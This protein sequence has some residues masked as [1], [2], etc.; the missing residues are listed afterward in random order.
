MVILILGTRA[1]RTVVFVAIAE[2]DDFV[3]QRRAGRPLEPAVE[4]RRHVLL[5]GVIAD[6][7]P[8]PKPVEPFELHAEG[9]AGLDAAVG[10]DQVVLGL[11]P[12]A[13]A[14]VFVAFCVVVGRDPAAVAEAF[15]R[16]RNGARCAFGSQPNFSF[17][18]KPLRSFLTS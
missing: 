6:E 3:P 11:D 4:Q 13:R 2:V 12:P 10:A 16:F 5:R 15:S 8:L 14:D 1:Q 7:E 9:H 17:Q 18:T